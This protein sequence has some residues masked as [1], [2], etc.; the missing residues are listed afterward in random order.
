VSSTRDASKK[1]SLISLNRFCFGFG[2]SDEETTYSLDGPLLLEK[3]VL[4]D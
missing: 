2:H 1:W 3:E 4:Q